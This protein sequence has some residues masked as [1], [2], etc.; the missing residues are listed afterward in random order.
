[1]NHVNLETFDGRD[2]QTSKTIIALFEEA[3]VS[4]IRV[5]RQRLEEYLRERAMATKMAVPLDR[6]H[7]A[8][9]QKGPPAAFCKSYGD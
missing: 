8:G 6:R 3:G 2:L 7:R 5:M 4:D 1:M 9:R